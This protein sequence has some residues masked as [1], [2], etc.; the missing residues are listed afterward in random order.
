MSEILLDAAPRKSRELYEKALAAMERDNLDYAMDMFTSALEIEPRLLRARKFLRAAA[1]KKFKDN[2]GGAVTHVI[3]SLTGLPGILGV[4]SQIKKKPTQALKGAEKLIRKDPLNLTFVN[5]LA[6]AAAAAEMPEVAIQTLEIARDHYPKNTALL[7]TLGRLYIETNQTQEARATYETLNTLRPNDPMIIKALKDTAALDTMRKGGWAE[8]GS[9]RDVM[10]DSK[11]ATILEQESK[12]V[13]S[14]KDIGE[15]I[16]EV[17]GKVEREPENMNY[18]RHLADL[19][20]RADRYDEAIAVL[21]EAHEST[22]RTDPQIDRALSGLRSKY[23]EFQ[24]AQLRKAGDT[25]G[26]EQKEKEKDTFL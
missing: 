20:S 5:L 18:K 6:Q 2:K 9:Y 21:T 3:S 22:G 24:V 14:D 15:L 26:A 4:M 7:K 25:A 11:E 13:K 19:L 17:Q 12:A 1:V 23:F 8:A 16:T 10:K